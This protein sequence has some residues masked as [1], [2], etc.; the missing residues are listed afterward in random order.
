VF[1]R[2]R[3]ISE[4]FSRKEKVAEDPLA[5]VVTEVTWG[6]RHSWIRSK[7][8]RWGGVLNRLSTSI[9][10]TV[11]SLLQAERGLSNNVESA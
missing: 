9:I 10:L 1:G 2:V 7:A 5:T 11:V 4:R 3:D 8:G 6:G